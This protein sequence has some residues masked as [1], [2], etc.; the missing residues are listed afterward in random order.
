M[1]FLLNMA[2]VAEQALEVLPKQKRL[3]AEAMRIR[4]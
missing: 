1:D 3:K 2:V 4:V